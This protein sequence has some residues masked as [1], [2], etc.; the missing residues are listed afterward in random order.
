M[1]ERAK[2]EYPMMGFETGEGTR[3][4]DLVQRIELMETMIAEGRRATVRFGWIFLMWGLLYFAAIGWEM[5]LPAAANF[6]WPVCMTLGFVI[7][8]IWRWR[9]K[10]SGLGDEGPRS[11]SISAVW[12]AM[13][14]AIS[15]Y[16]LSAALSHHIGQQPAVNAA[17]MIFLG[18]AHAASA[19]ILRWRAQ[20][21]VAAVWW[22]GGIAIFFAPA[23]SILIFLLA[24]F[25]GMVLFGV[26]AM[27]LERR[28]AALV[29]HHA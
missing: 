19:L 2:E 3:R 16:M 17:V 21:A 12:S 9:L 24:T 20:G 27:M 25:F 13:G 8:W 5:F 18:L 22:A 7:I 23:S 28:T 29:E 26:Y 14:C 15:I 6:A 11:R 4:E 10:R 1:P